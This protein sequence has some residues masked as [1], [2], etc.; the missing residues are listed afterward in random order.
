M[1]KYIR[2][3]YFKIISISSLFYRSYLNLRGIEC[4]AKLKIR[5]LPRIIKYP[6]SSIKIGDKCKMNSSLLSNGIGLNHPT[7]IRTIGKRT[8][9]DIGNNVGMS[10]GTILARKKIV[11]EDNILLGANFFITDSDHHPLDPQKRLDNDEETIR[12]K[13]VIIK[14]N[15]FIGAYTI[16]LKGVTIGK[17]SIIGAGSVVV[18][19]IPDN[20]IARGNP[21]EVVK[22]F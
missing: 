8:I 6:G 17:N 10:G 5:G 13:S 15:A 4:G 16:I 19:D 3:F 2:S 12:S 18:S 20:C 14:E 22:E 1:R 21:A 11:L 7:I 9:I